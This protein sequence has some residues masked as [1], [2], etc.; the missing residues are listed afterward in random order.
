MIK[1]MSF[2]ISQVP[3]YPDVAQNLRFLISYQSSALLFPLSTTIS[4]GSGVQA[5]DTI[6]HTLG[7]L[8]RNTEYSV[9]I[10]AQVQFSACYVAMTGA[11]SD[12]MTFRTSNMC[13]YNI[14]CVVN[15]SMGDL[16][17]AAIVCWATL[18]PSPT[19]LPYHSESV[20]LLCQTCVSL[21]QWSRLSRTSRGVL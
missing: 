5:G 2:I 15:Y 11:L 18:L 20:Q 9:Q 12:Q 4:S 8:T 3:K 6:S 7:S 1:S 16:S 21:Q 17:I 10:R 14:L 19:F 13:T